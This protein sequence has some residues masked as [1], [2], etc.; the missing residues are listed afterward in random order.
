QK[1]CFTGLAAITGIARRVGA[2]RPHGCT[3]VGSSRIQPRWTRASPRAKARSDDTVRAIQQGSH[4]T[5]HS[6]SVCALRSSLALL[7]GRRRALLAAIHP[8]PTPRTLRHG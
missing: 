7:L 8:V 1:A 5:D 6:P 3:L 2:S 4:H